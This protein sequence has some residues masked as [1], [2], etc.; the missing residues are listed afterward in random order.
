KE[1]LG[2]RGRIGAGPE[3]GIG[4]D[5]RPLVDERGQAELA[6]Q[7]GEG[8]L[9]TLSG[10]SMRV[11]TRAMV[12]LP[13]RFG[14]TIMK[15]FWYRLSAVSMSPNISCSVSRARLPSSSP[16]HNC[17]RKLCHSGG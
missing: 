13:E 9:A 2:D 12:P 5:G 14:P 8:G 16:G 6:A 3:P 4:N 15:I 1:A 10:A 7:A 17:R 11:N